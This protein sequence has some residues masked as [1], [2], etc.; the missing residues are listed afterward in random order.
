MPYFPDLLIKERLNT[1][2]KPLSSTPWINEQ[3]LSEKPKPCTLVQW[4]QWIY[5]HYLWH[6]WL[7]SFLFKIHKRHFWFMI[8]QQL[9]FKV[10]S[11]IFALCMANYEWFFLYAIKKQMLL[12]FYLVF[13]R[14]HKL[15]TMWVREA[16]FFVFIEKLSPGIN[17][18]R[19]D[20]PWLESPAKDCSFQKTQHLFS[21]KET[22][23]DIYKLG[24]E[25]SY[26]S[27]KKYNFKWYLCMT[28]STSNQSINLGMIFSC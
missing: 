1:T 26:N 12:Q 8:Y 5:C 6:R 15:D 3:S 18:W 10:P 11:C 28:Y 21:N 24:D 7:Q 2:Q 23:W 20:S 13:F 14:V 19:C 17:K 25:H 27:S 4:F 16:V 22:H 9:R